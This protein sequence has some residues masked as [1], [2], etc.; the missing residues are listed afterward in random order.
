MLYLHVSIPINHMTPVHV[1]LHTIYCMLL[2][3]MIDASHHQTCLRLSGPTAG[4]ILIS[5]IR[6]CFTICLINLAGLKFLQKWYCIL[7]ALAAAGEDVWYLR[8]ESIGHGLEM[9]IEGFIEVYD[10]GVEGNA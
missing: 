10:S 1:G 8:S 3:P 4:C 2:T 9:V 6:R 5:S 7:R